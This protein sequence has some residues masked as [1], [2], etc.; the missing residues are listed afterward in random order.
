MQTL[1]TS[2]STRNKHRSSQP[3]M[4]YLYHTY[5]HAHM[6]THTLTKAQVPLWKKGKDIVIKGGQED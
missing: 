3:Q 5:M 2:Q 1:T 4:G 6:H